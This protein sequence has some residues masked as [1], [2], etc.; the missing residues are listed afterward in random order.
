M[1]EN[2]RYIGIFEMHGVS[3][4]TEGTLDEVVQGLT[5]VIRNA[6]NFFGGINWEH[7]LRVVKLGEELS[8]GEVEQIVRNVK[9][10]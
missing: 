10:D 2:G 4:V 7:S 1:S 6:K 5:P 8:I 9:T 3:H